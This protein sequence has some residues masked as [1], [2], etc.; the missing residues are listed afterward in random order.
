MEVCLQLP[1]LHRSEERRLTGGM[2]P[3]LHS[4]Q[5]QQPLKAPLHG[6][7][8][9]QLLLQWSMCSLCA[10]HSMH[11]QNYHLVQGVQGT[12]ATSCPMQQPG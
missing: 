1:P 10:D 6:A 4:L 3:Q 12:F 7:Q 8:S 5:A 11:R 2:A 9:R